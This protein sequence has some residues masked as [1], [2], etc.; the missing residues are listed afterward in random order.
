MKSQWA[1][2]QLGIFSGGDRQVRNRLVRVRLDW[3]WQDTWALVLSLT[4]L[5]LLLAMTGR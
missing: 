2:A 3:D 5:V 1:R 4:V